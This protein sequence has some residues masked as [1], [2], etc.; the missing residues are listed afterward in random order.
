MKKAAKA[1]YEHITVI[2]PACGKKM[3]M[4]KHK[5]LSTEG[6]LCQKCGMG[7]EKPGHD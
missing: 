4:L 3:H 1:D 6:M 2:C 5:R 7:A